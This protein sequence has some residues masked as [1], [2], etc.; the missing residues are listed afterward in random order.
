MAWFHFCAV[1]GKAKLRDP[2]HLSGDTGQ[3]LL[4]GGLTE[5]SGMGLDYLLTVVVDTVCVHLSNSHY[6]FKWLNFIQINFL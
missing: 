2:K 5:L 4:H 1:L 6:I 3:N